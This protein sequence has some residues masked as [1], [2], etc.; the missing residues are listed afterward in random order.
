MFFGKRKAAERA[1]LEKMKRDEEEA[2]ARQKAFEERQ[3]AAAA[4]LAARPSYEEMAGTPSDVFP[5]KR[6]SVVDEG[7]DWQRYNNI[8]MYGDGEPVDIVIWE[9]VFL[10]ETPLKHYELGEL[11]PKDSEI[12]ALRSA[13]MKYYA[14]LVDV[15]Y[16]KNDCP[17]ASV[18]VFWYA[19][20]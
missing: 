6:T 20:N 17:C 7:M 12:F 3:A 16:D 11:S 13:T 2:A 19:K 1:A 10:V 18:E 14:Y 8:G 5:L 15:D 4:E 9:P